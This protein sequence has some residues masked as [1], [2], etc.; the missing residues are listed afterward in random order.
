MIQVEKFFRISMLLVSMLLIV[1]C[2]VDRQTENYDFEANS[3]L[4]LRV[5][6]HPHGYGKATCFNCH[7]QQNIHEVDRL[8]DSS[9]SFAK[10]LVEAN[11]LKSCS[12][13]HGSNGVTQ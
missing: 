11:G 9:F 12:G 13:C 8:H 1:G 10:P 5:S 7:L 2:A 3:P 4:N 6:N